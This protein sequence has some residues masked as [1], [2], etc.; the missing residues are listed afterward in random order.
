[1]GGAGILARLRRHWAI[2]VLLVGSGAV[3]ARTAGAY[4]MLMWDEA[5]YAS[6]ARAL[7]HGEGYA[8]GGS[9]HA[10]RP[11]LL[12][13][14][15]T[16]GLWLAGRADDAAVHAV[17][18]A[19]ALLA[20]LLIYAGATAVYD[21]ATGFAAAVLL[22]SAPWFWTTTANALSEIPFLACFAAASF[23]WSGGLLCDARWFYASWL[24]V[25][26]AF[27]TRYTALLLG[28]LAVLL[29][30]L[31]LARG[32]TAVRQR[33]GSRPFVLA[34]LVGLAVVA[35]WVVRQA[36]VFGDPLVGVRH[37]STQLQVY[38][39]G[40]SMP[41]WSYLAGLPGLLSWPTAA[42]LGIGAAAALW[43]RDRFALHAL[44][45]VAFVLAWFSAY[46]YKEPRLVSAMLPAAALLAALGLTRAPVEPV[47]R[48]ALAGILAAIALL[49]F[50][51]TRPT[52][53]AV[54]TIGY[55]S[56]LDAMAFVREH[57]ARD[58]LLIG[59]NEPQMVWYAERAVVDFPARREDLAPLLARAEWVVVTNFERGQK[60]WVAPLVAHLPAEAFADGSA[61]RFD[62]GRFTT[63]VVRPARLRELALGAP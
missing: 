12:P 19:L 62:D 36:L 25:G 53:A 13:L 27:L 31:E 7:L 56:F 4:G 22:G 30:L 8:I 23:A 40:V 18:I 50:S 57:S 1:V 33:V 59:P 60:P 45:A 5:E 47:P 46:R 24:A 34:P 15:E 14:A 55:P 44:V 37:A 2:G 20:L 28:P 42:L 11:P 58:A 41:W 6:L 52:F 54:R 26:L 16:A 38:L 21:R 29:T 3:Y 10:L 49:N 48:A 32:D 9:P 17:T 63:L 35:P 43:R 39:P 61:V 51:A